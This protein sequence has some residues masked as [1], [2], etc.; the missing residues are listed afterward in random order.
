VPS[1][2]Y[3]LRLG[4]QNIQPAKIVADAAIARSG[5]VG[6]RLI[7]LV[8]VEGAN[9]PELEEMVRLHEATVKPGDVQV[10]WGQIDGHEDTVA[11][12]LKFIRPLEFCLVLEFT[13]AR[14]GIL[15][16]QALAA[17][18]LYIQVGKEGDRLGTDIDRPKV[19]IEI[20]D[21]GFKPT[22]DQMFHKAISRDFRKEGVSR[23]ESRR[24]AKAM[25]E[26]LRD[27]GSFRMPEPAD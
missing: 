2:K 16:D 12:F 6:G 7:P 9:H 26:M 11:V 4:G 17:R 13:I 19:L 8:I 21:T 20:A 10:S 15:V 25:I 24:K 1:G 5:L 14:Q 22:W 23:T 3:K 18:G 27:T